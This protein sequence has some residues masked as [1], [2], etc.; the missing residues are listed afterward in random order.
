MSRKAGRAGI[1][2]I[3]KPRNLAEK[4]RMIL[5]LEV[6]CTCATTTMLLANAQVPPDIA[7]ASTGK[8]TKGWATINTLQFS[9]IGPWIDILTIRHQAPRYSM[10]FRRHATE[11]R[12][13]EIPKC[14][15][16]IKFR[17]RKV[18]PART[19]RRTTPFARE[20]S[21]RLAAGEAPDRGSGR[22][23]RAA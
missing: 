16:G 21:S 11:S 4:S 20:A 7:C 10:A 13:W 2:I 19:T 5:W 9:S 23:T 8:A 17:V 12:K 14:S 18:G 3:K 1:I 6:D 15:D 22:C